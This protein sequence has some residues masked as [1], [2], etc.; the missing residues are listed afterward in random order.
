MTLPSGQE[1]VNE[2]LKMKKY[3]PGENQLEITGLTGTSYTVSVYG[4]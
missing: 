4:F 3:F 1:A 2:C